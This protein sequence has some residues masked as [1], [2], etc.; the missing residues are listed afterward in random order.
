[1]WSCPVCNRSFKTRNQ[2]HSCIQQNVES[3]FQNKPP[4][5]KLL[6]DQL[7]RRI[8]EIGE[9]RQSVVKSAI[10]LK[11][12]AT[13]ME[14]KARKDYIELGFYLDE[15]IKEFPIIR[16]L[17]V[18]KNRIE[19]VIHLHQSSDIDDQLMHYLRRSYSIIK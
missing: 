15:E 18:S 14:I 5:I 6:F 1:M 3:H 12:E 19:H 2:Y 11:K 7:L 13:F 8:S 10:F 16:T 9:T 4:E 17:R